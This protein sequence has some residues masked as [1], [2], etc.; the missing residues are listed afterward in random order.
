MLLNASGI[1]FSVGLHFLSRRQKLQCII[2]LSISC[3]RKEFFLAILIVLIKEKMFLPEVQKIFSHRAVLYIIFPWGRQTQA[4]P[5]Y[6]RLRPYLSVISFAQLGHTE[7][8]IKID[9]M[10]AFLSHEHR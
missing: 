2:S 6:E 7:C 9:E 10:I 4:L 5:S 1:P 8:M 3:R